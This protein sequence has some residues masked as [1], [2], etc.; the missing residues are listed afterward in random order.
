MKKAK[1]SSDDSDKSVKSSPTK[2]KTAKKA[3]HQTLTER[4]P[5]PKLWDPESNPDSYSK[6]SHVMHTGLYNMYPSSLF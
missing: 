6:F 3:G 5:L 4:D 1:A 2:K